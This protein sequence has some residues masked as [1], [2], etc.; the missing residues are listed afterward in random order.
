MGEIQEV[1]CRVGTR[2]CFQGWVWKEMAMECA[3]GRYSSTWIAC[4]KVGNARSII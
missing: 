2:E 1:T 4:I 3:E